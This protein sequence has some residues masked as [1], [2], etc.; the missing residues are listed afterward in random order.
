MSWWSGL[1]QREIKRGLDILGRDAERTEHDGLAYWSVRD[2]SKPR[3]A[4]GVWLLPN[5][6]EFLIAYRDRQLSAPG[7]TLKPRDIYAHFLVID[8][9][10]A[11]V[12]RRT[13]TGVGA[14]VVTTPYRR[15]TTTETRS[16]KT[17]EEAF[18]AFHRG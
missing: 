14:R 17:A 8:G 11:G 4:S 3:P 15:L 10:L 9:V 16:L 1:P 2:R 12:W 5:Y 18:A 6:D 13:G 7:F